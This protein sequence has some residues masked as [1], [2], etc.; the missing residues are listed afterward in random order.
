MIRGKYIA[1]CGIEGAGKDSQIELLAKKLRSKKIPVHITREPGGGNLTSKR[2]REITQN[3]EYP[4]NTKT[5]TLLYNASRSQSLDDVEDMLSRGVWVISNRNYVCSLAIQYYA[6]QPEDITYEQINQICEFAVGE[7]TGDLNFILDITPEES[8]D[9]KHKYRGGERF[10]NLDLD[11]LTRMRDGYLIEAEKRNLTVIDA[12]RSVDKTAAA[13]WTHVNQLIKGENKGPESLASI[14]ESKSVSGTTPTFTSAAAVASTTSATLAQN[15]YLSKTTNGFEITD[16]GKAYLD[17]AVTNHD[18]N[19]YAFKPGYNQSTVAAAM[20]R[21]SRRSGDLR[22]TILDEFA[23]SADKDEKL[24]KRVISAYGDDS[25]QQLTGIHLVVEGAS[26]LLTK[27]LERG[28]LA[29]YLEQ[30]TRYI[31]F[32]KKDRAGNYL[33]YTPTNLNAKTAEI[34]EKTMDQMFEVYSEVVRSLTTYVET[35]STTPEGERDGAWKSACRAQACDAARGLLPVATKSTVG[36]YASGQALESLI[37][38]LNSEN[39]VES[40]TTATALLAE[41]R[42]V[43]PSFLERADLPER[44]SATSAYLATTSAALKKLADANLDKHFAVQSKKQ[45]SSSQNSAIN[46]NSAAE[47]TVGENALIGQVE[48]IEFWPKNELNLLPHMLYEHSDIGLT[49]L[50][51]SLGHVS[52]SERVEMMKSYFGERLN[53]RHKPGRALEVAHYTFDIVCDY[54]IFRDL[55][56]HRMVDAM[57]W[58]TLTPRLGYETPKLVSQAGLDDLYDTCFDLSLSL[59][60]KLTAAGYTEEAQYATLLGH[61]MRWT[62]T[63][64]ARQAFHLHELRTTPHGHPNYRA[65]VKLMHQ[66]VAAVHPLIA[67]A[68]IFVGKDENPDLTR[69]AAERATQ[70]KMQQL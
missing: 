28:R 53:R 46:S 17:Q 12:M 15:I 45:S 39:L 52:Y 64:N 47:E 40:R 42:K 5:E 36:I 27:K 63:Y 4:L 7:M 35:N 54:G 37:I 38:R 68:M 58:Q 24:L 2:I 43:I 19:I 11:F 32:D 69:L 48:L 21:L 49:E 70:F 65:L 62:M 23:G 25:V 33:Y 67:E 61:K 34:Y 22:E 18:K 9:R 60:S 10:D 44:G 26:N 55:Q 41:A 8:A 14:L 50:E 13:V 59:H 30:S 6:R 20:A 57:E 1:F 66:K 3:T 29:S 56:R 16:A 31:Y 51:E